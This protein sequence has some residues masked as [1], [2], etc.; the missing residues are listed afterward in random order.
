[1]MADPDFRALEDFSTSRESFSLRE[2]R[3]AVN[4]GSDLFVLLRALLPALSRLRLAWRKE[5]GE[6]IIFR[7]HRTDPFMPDKKELTDAE[8]RLNGGELPAG[9]Q[10][11][12]EEYIGQK[13]GKPWDNAVTLQ[14]I[15]TSVMLQKSQYWEERDK[16][17]IGYRKG[18]AVFAYLAYHA[19]VSFFQFSYLFLRLIREGSIPG[20]IRILDAGAGPGVVPL[21]ISG[22]LQEL[23]GLSAEIFAL[24]RSDEFIDAYCHLVPE[25]ARMSA[26]ITIHP[27]L[28]GDIRA[29]DTLLLPSSV[30]LIVMQNVLNELPGE[31][32]NTAGIVTTLSRLLTP[33]G[34]MAIIEPADRE[35]SITL[36]KIVNA[37]TGKDLVV[38]DPCRFLWGGSCRAGSCWSFQEKPPIRPTRLMQALAGGKEAFRFENTD[39]KFSYAVLAGVRQKPYSRTIPK[40]A[41]FL[42]LSS[43]RRHT[44]KNVNVTAAVMS[45]DIGDPQHHVF[46]ICDGTGTAYA[47]LPRYHVMPGNRALLEVAYSSVIEFRRVLVRYNRRYR[48]WN[49]LLSKNSS[50]RQALGPHPGVKTD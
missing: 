9:I 6:I 46:L 28:K 10:R 23:P 20:Q 31:T 2:F 45:G 35:N 43:L 11:L 42:P 18:Y 3:D 13:T 12:V 26:G 5:K 47:I 16:R 1:M 29:A 15:R 41:S 38:R 27:P 49:L 39:I 19:P 37:A 30:D 8:N 40:G 14:R 21:A 44:G 4:P 25:Y 17:K 33:E 7:H 48:A 24:E 32:G 34:C 36:R 22:L 50:A